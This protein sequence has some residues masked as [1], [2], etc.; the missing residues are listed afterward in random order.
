MSSGRIRKAIDLR[1]LLLAGASVLVICSPGWSQTAE[2]TLAD[3]FRAGQQAAAERRFDRAI[4]EF[5]AVLKLDPTL[6]EARANLG[7]MYYSTGEFA[8]AAAELAKVSTA[9]P[10]LLPGQLFLGLSYLSLGKTQLAIPPLRKALQLEPGNAEAQRGLLTCYLRLGE[11]QQATARIQSLEA[12]PAQEEILYAI[13]QAYLEMGRGLTLQMAQHYRSSAW[14]HRLAGDLAADRGDWQEAA[15]SYRRAL[16]IDSGLPGLR[17]AYAEAL[18]KGGKPANSADQELPK[19][20]PSGAAPVVCTANNLQ[21]C[22][23]RLASK[24]D[25][26]L[27]YALIRADADLGN[28]YFGKLQDLF[29][30]SARA[31][32]LR[33]E[34]YRLRQDFPG[35]IAEFQAALQ[36][37]PDDAELHR[38]AGEMLL[39]LDRVNEAEVELKRAAELGPGN[40]Q[41]EYLLAQLCLK[42]K[43]MAGAAV[44]LKESLKHDPESAEAHALLGTAYMHLDKPALAVP[45]L[46]KAQ[47]IDYRGDLNFQLYQ[48]VP[49]VGQSG[50]RRKGAG[51]LKGTAEEQPRFS[52]SEN[53]RR[54]QLRYIS[55][56]DRQAGSEH[57][58]TAQETAPPHDCRTMIWKSSRISRPVR[59]GFSS[60]CSIAVIAAAPISA[61]GW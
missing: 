30:D 6:A 28:Q 18:R 29:P 14:A 43:D 1:A 7:L 3:H 60:L 21:H 4:V 42:K 48:G 25:P 54:E 10:D 19:S 11:Y 58:D 52:G 56:R 31:H 2:R 8:K 32:E 15:E 38:Y 24:E 23:K 47:A 9:A 57:R 37:R 27:L 53:K 16:A 12:L 51:S 39:L 41:T 5:Q 26:E 55:G 22:E 34:I 40:A 50:S 61:Q 33:G 49:G 44:Y 36:K 17:L 45:E 59:P 20:E 46:E 35:A 13:G